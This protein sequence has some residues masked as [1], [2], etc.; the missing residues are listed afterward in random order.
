MASLELLKRY[1]GF[2]SNFGTTEYH[3]GGEATIPLSE[4]LRM[5]REKEPLVVAPGAKGVKKERALA[6]FPHQKL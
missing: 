1:R 5:E 6:L 2:A 3:R 4:A